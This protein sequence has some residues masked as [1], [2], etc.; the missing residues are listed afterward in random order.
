MSPM[1]V[2]P[3]LLTVITPFVMV[4]GTARAAEQQIILA[5]AQTPQQIEEERKRRLQQQQQ[6]QQQQQHGQGQQQQQPHNAQGAQ[7]PQQH[8]AQEQQQH[9][10]QQKA[11]EQQHIQQQAQEKTL[12]QQKAAQHQQELLKQQEAQRKA[13]EDARLRD[14]QARIHQLQG[15]QRHSEQEL[16]LE[17]QKAAAQQQQAHQQQTAMH[18]E[19]SAEEQKARAERDTHRLD[20]ERLIEQQRRTEQAEHSQAAINERLRLQNERLQAITSQRREIVDA[21]GHKYIQEPGNRTIFQV[22]NQAFIRHDESVNFRFY[23]G[24]AQTQRG[25]NGNMISNIYR[26]DG[27]RIEV[28]VDMYGRPLRRVRYLPDGRR[29]VLF[30]NRAIMAGVGLA[31]LGA[32]V[33]A[34]PPAHVDIPRAEYIVDAG[35]ASEDDIYGALQAPPVEPLDH[36]YSLDEVLASVSLRERMRSISIDTIRFD[37]GSAEVAPEQAV[38]L[39]TVAAVIRNMSNGNPGEVFLIE[40]HTDAVG[41]D[42]DNLSLSDRRAQGV[43]DVL[44]QQFGVPRENLV[45]QGYGK[46]FL[47]IPTDGP[48]RRNR[49]VVVRRIT[50]LLQGEQSRYSSSGYGAPEGEARQ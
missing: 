10:Q 8:N 40:G 30:E 42:M 22:N 36:V 45:T 32:F 39:E 46:Q 29:F 15:Q 48:E 35:A 11:L 33:V 2:M 44:S 4:S 47:L 34:L 21:G 17:R 16:Q 50:P 19:L 41:S 38:M 5:Q 31:A 1:K 24:N 25:P 27:S 3:L 37:F 18:R 9:L 49:R 43:A 26:P 28:E 20:R 6:Q 12:E 13:Q 14:E 23:G 7:P